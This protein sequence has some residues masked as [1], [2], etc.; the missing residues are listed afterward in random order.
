MD[1]NDNK[2]YST[3]IVEFDCHKHKDFVDENHG[4]V[5][6]GDLIIITNSKLEKLVSKGPNFRETM[7]I[8]W[9][10]CK[11][12]IEIDLD[13]SIERI[14]LTNPKVTTEEFIEWKRKILQEVDNRIISLKHRINVHKANLVLKQDTI[15]EYLN[16]LHEKF[17]FV[18]FDTVASNIAIIC[19]KYYKLMSL[20]FSKKLQY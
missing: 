4:H 17:V 2:T 14:I 13:S 15:T 18:Q 3:G 7:L 20:L 8:N 11:R 5:L 9:N 10:K 16:E 12:E 6:T 19:E 1:I